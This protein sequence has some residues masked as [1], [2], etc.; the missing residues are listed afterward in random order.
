MTA[1]PATRA[2]RSLA[3]VLLLGGLLSLAAC[4]PVARRDPRPNVVLVISDDQDFEHFGFAGH[5]LART[6]AIDDLARGGLSFPV[7]WSAPRCRPTLAGMLSGRAPRHSGLYYGSGPGGLHGGPFLPALLRD[8]GYATYVGGKLFEDPKEMGFTD[9]T[10]AAAS[11]AGLDV[12][13]F[14]RDGQEALFSFLERERD[15]PFFV[16]W[17]PML[18]H[19]PHDPPDRLRERFSPEAIEVPPWIAAAD[20]P[21]YREREATSLAMVAWLDEG[22]AALRGELRDLGLEEHTL[23]L[24]LIDNG[25]SNGDVSKGSPYEHGVR[26]PL[27]VSWPGHVVPGTEPAHLASYLDVLPTV[28]DYAG[29]AFPEGLDG[30]SLRPFAEGVGEPR[31]TLFGAC[32]PELAHVRGLP[33]RDVLALAARDARWK[34]VRWVRGIAEQD[35]EHR[36]RIKHL[37]VP[38][39]AREAGTEELYDLQRDPHECS[40]LSAD[41]EN[42]AELADFRARV[43]AW[44][45]GG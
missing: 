10:D 35:N 45:D 22:V 38:F 7:A 8:A 33:E 40:D 13:G 16:W 42:A 32:Y 2:R 21:A 11:S 24:F 5:P 43:D 12:E 25:W 18:P 20:A 30:V 23:I 17:A 6:P 28:L 4:G 36:L 9:G 41:P 34:Y 31:R 1:A 3:P 26:T 29:V 15:R 39:P 27:V 14:V 37:G 19:V 44:W